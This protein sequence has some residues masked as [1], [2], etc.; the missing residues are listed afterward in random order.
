MLEITLFRTRRV[1][2]E[3]E[4]EGATIFHSGRSKYLLRFPDKLRVKNH[5][6]AFSSH[7]MQFLPLSMRYEFFRPSTLLYLLRVRTRNL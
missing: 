6:S 2:M 3:F 1:E 5:F 4:S 7:R